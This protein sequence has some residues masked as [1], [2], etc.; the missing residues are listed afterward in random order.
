MSKPATRHWTNRAH[1]FSPLQNGLWHQSPGNQG[2]GGNRR[3][4]SVIDAD[5]LPSS[6]LK[7]SAG[8]VI[9]IINNNDHSVQVSFYLV[10]LLEGKN[11]LITRQSRVHNRYGKC[12]NLAESLI[13]MFS[14][15]LCAVS[16]QQQ[17]KFCPLRGWTRWDFVV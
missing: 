17:A 4:S 12:R 1:T 16:Y 15:V 2:W 14:P 8:R 11:S 5:N 13:Y 3:K 7:P 6:S 10:L 9:R